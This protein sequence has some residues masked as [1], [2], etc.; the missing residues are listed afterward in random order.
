MDSDMFEIGP[1]LVWSFDWSGTMV[2]NTV[3][4]AKANLSQLLDLV[5]KGEE[6][7]L[8]RAGKPVAI[9][10][11]YRRSGRPRQPG[12]LRGQIRISAD[13]DALPLEIAEAFGVKTDGIERP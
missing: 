8:S 10:E 4:E 2:V 3:T 11:P 5:D 12:S 1:D 6:V 7:I 13:F 9:L